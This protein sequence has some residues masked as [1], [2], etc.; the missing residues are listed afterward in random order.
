VTPEEFIREFVANLRA[1]SAELTAYGAIESAKACEQVATD[2]GLEFQKWWLEELTVAAAASESGYS[3]ERI[4]EMA[5]DGTLQHR[6]GE[7]VKGHLLIA[8]RNLPRRPN[9]IETRVS[10]LEER[11]LRPRQQDLRKPA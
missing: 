8:R 11:L 3:P 5:R 4:R 6:K 1:K 9:S 7:G 10:S 2:L